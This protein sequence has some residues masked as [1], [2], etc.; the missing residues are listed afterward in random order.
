MGKLVVTLA[1]E[2]FFGKYVMSS[3]VGGR[4]PGT[5]PLPEQGMSDI[6][7]PA[8]LKQEAVS[9]ETVWQKCKSAINHA[10]LKRVVCV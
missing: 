9:E 3:S 5:T 4:G 7:C 8:Y 1:R 10:C 6:L 2:C